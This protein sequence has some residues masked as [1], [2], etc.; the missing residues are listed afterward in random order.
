[1]C[2]AVP[3]SA[4]GEGPWKTRAT[5]IVPKAQKDATDLSYERSFEF[6]SRTLAGKSKV[7]A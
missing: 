3:S 1:M 2:A 7:T 4:W 6:L 5:A